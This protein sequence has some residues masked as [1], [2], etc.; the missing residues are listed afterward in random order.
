MRYWLLTGNPAKQGLFPILNRNDIIAYINIIKSWDQWTV[1][2][3]KILK[4][5]GFY[6]MLL[7]QHDLNGIIAR[8]TI[9]K[10]P[11]PI[12]YSPGGQSALFAGIEF[13]NTQRYVACDTLKERFPDQLW[14]PQSS[15]ISIR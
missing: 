1:T 6:L 8:G 3:K 10:E 2:S 7:G 15:G 12:N 13:I 11:E 9:I 4:G 5:D 14:T